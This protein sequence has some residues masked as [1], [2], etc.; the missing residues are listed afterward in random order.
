MSYKLKMKKGDKVIVMA[1]K[2]KGKSGEIF[3]IFPKEN[4]ALVQG[5]NIVRRHKKQTQESEGGIIAGESKI[6][7]SNL[8]MVD[9]KDG[10]ATRIGFQFDKEGVKKRFAKRSGEMIDG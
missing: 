6:H 1:G 9:P 10:K 7:I 2:D 8:A 4:R 5:V 3:A